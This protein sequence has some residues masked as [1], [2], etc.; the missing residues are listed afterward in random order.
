MPGLESL[1]ITS[2]SSTCESSYLTPSIKDFMLDF[3]YNL[4]FGHDNPFP[5]FLDVCVNFLKQ[6]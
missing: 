2:T 4:Q 1:I 3:Q 5:E 6:T